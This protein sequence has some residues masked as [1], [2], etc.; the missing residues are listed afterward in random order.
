M[1]QKKMVIY[2]KK[3]SNVANTSLGTYFST[4]ETNFSFIDVFLHQNPLL[5]AMLLAIF[6]IEGI[7]NNFS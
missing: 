1:D 4:L 7:E 5:K 3:F 2:F 6:N